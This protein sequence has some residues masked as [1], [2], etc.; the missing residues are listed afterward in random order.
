LGVVFSDLSNNEPYST[1]RAI[2][3]N[4]LSNPEPNHASGTPEHR[5]DYLPIPSLRAPQSA[6]KRNAQFGW[7]CMLWVPVILVV[8]PLLARGFL[9]I[10]VYL[11][12]PFLGLIIAVGLMA[13]KKYRWFGIGMLAGILLFGLVYGFLFWQMATALSEN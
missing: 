4:P 3:G 9:S 13:T 2:M 11:G 8:T 6:S 7:G 5:G 10:W 1:R 12:V